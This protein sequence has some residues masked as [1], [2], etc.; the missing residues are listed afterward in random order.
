MAE[1]APHVLRELGEQTIVSV[2]D[3]HKVSYTFELVIN[4]TELS[5]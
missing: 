4:W 2:L 1:W 3:S 5:K